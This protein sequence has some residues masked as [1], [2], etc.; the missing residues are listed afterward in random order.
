MFAKSLFQVKE[1]PDKGKGL[2]ALEDVPKGTIVSFDCR[3]CVSLPLS[4][5]DTVSQEDRDY[6]LRYTYKQSD[7]TLASTCNNAVLYLNHSCA[8]NILGVESGIDLV[9]DAIPEGHEATYDY[10]IF[11]DDGYQFDC[12]CGALNCCRKLVC[13]H[14]IPGALKQ[15]WNKKVSE[16][17]AQAPLVKQPLHDKVY[18]SS[19]SIQQFLLRKYMGRSLCTDN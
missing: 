16:A 12:K 7:G 2:F 17:L 19:S 11:H 15:F 1:T 8:A 9:V 14:P 13:E 4:V 3:R 10:R 5:L 18:L 6:F